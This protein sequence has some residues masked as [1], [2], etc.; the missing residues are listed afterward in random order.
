M[1]EVTV[2]IPNYNGQKY[3][4]PC[5]K[6]LYENTKIAMDVIVVDNGSM[7]Q[8]ASEAQ[9]AYPQA[10]YIFF[11]KN[12]GFC[13]AVNEGIRAAHTEYV[14]LL[15]NDTEIKE[16]FVENLLRTIKKNKMIFSV[17]AKM[18]QYGNQEFIDSAGTYYNALGWAFAR[19]KDT[20]V[21]KY[22]QRCQTFAA[23]A[24]AA[25][26]RKNVFEKIGYFDENHFAYLEDID[27]GYRAK[28]Y[29]YKNLYEPKA[30]VIH[31]GSASSGSRYNE[32]KTRYSARNNIYLIYKNMPALQIVLNLPTLMAGFLAKA[33]FFGRI[34]FGKLYL[35]S[36]KEGLSLCKPECKVNFQKNNLKNYAMIQ[37]ELWVNIIRRFV[38]KDS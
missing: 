25:I 23:C 32:F 14:L 16:G 28:I 37:C 29:G 35:N 5:M 18:I 20:S 19:G 13:R 36:L 6:A 26:Y 10:T 2:V 17:E 11:D 7:D 9:K 1:Q 24:G 12:Y 34:G 3:L 31:V 38:K 21:S 33:V 22:N 4:I 8:S 15:N 30:K 27:I